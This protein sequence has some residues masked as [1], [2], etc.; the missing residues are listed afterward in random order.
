VTQVQS[1]TIA[2]HQHDRHD[3]QWLRQTG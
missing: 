3:Y 1:T 2:E